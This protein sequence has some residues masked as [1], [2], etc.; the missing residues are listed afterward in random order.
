MRQ[1]PGAVKSFVAEYA[2]SWGDAS[3][4]RRRHPLRYPVHTMTN[5]F[6]SSLLDTM[7]KVLYL[8][9]GSCQYLDRETGELMWLVDASDEKHWWKVASPNLYQAV[10]ELG[11][12]I[13]VEWEE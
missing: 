8:H 2:F 1:S 10:Y 12:L 6:A 13:G 3:R 11:V 5:Y 9:T 4:S 7:G